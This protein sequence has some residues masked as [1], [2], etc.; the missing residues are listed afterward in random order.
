LVPFRDQLFDEY[1]TDWLLRQPTIR[2]SSQT[3][4]KEA[5]NCVLHN[6]TTSVMAGEEVTAIYLHPQWYS[7]YLVNGQKDNDKKLSAKFIGEVAEWLC[8]NTD[9]ELLRGGV[10]G[11]TTFRLTFKD[12]LIVIGD[13]F[14]QTIKDLHVTKTELPALDNV[15]VLKDENKKPTTFEMTED[16]Q[17][18]VDRLNEYNDLSR[19][20]SVGLLDDDDIE[21]DIQLRKI[22]SS[23]NWGLGGR[24]YVSNGVAQ[25]MSGKQRQR[26]LI[27]RERV[28]EIDFKTLHP[29]LV[30]EMKKIDISEHDPYAI[31]LDGYDG[32]ILRDIAKLSLLIMVNTKNP[33]SARMAINHRISEK[34]DVSGW[35]NQGLIPNEAVDTGLIM[36]SLVQHNEFMLDWLYTGRG[37]ELQNIDSKI[38]DYVINWFTQRGELVIPIHDSVVVRQSLTDTAEDVMMQAYESVMG[39]K[40]NCRL[41][42]K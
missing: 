33:Q 25:G 15:L 16:L 27:G 22:Y 26:L 36:K 21:Y 4:A 28:S 10:S 19:E 9:C 1:M 37:L 8:E 5:M 24:N 12:T 39:S 31:T 3:K 20:V 11:S 35:F 6:L 23:L 29:S 41:E 2:P 14:R 17:I 13:E 32:K 38:M 7:K 30:A 18:I 40:I 42:V 34:W